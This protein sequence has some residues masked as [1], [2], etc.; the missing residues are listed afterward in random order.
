MISVSLYVHWSDDIVICITDLLRTINVTEIVSSLYLILL[1]HPQFTPCII[2]ISRRVHDGS[3]PAADSPRGSPAYLLACRSQQGWAGQGLPEQDRHP[4]PPIVQSHT[5]NLAFRP[6]C[7]R[8]CPPGRLG[9]LGCE[10]ECRAL[11]WTYLGRRLAPPRLID[12]TLMGGIR[13]G[14]GLPS[15]K[16]SKLGLVDTTRISLCVPALDHYMTNFVTSNQFPGH[17]DIGRFG[18]ALLT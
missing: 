13:S 9:S 10:C 18:G 2:V 8:L 16:I 14:T 12:A 4:S 3:F 17:E 1:L 5:H 11:T 7:V 15:K 6:A